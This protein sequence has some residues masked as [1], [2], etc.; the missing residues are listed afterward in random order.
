MTALCF[1]A[2]ILVFSTHGG[3][4]DVVRRQDFVVPLYGWRCFTRLDHWGEQV[5][6]FLLF[7]VLFPQNPIS[8]LNFVMPPCNTCSKI[9]CVARQPKVI[10]FRKI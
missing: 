7:E 3:V 6:R 4:G 5:F 2:I 8:E 9:R 1:S 10:R